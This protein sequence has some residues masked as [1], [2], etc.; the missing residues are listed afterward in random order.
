MTFAMACNCTAQSS[1]DPYPVDP[2]GHCKSCKKIQSGS[3]PDIIFIKPDGSLIRIAQIR[4]LSHVIT[5]KPYGARLRVVVI[6]NAQTMNPEAG[7]ALLKLLEE[8]PDRTI[9]ILTA[10]QTSDLLPTI[11]SRC[12]HIRFNPISQKE[13]MKMLVTKQEVAPDDAEII[14]TMA[15]GS[16]SKAISIAR[17]VNKVNWINRRNWLINIISQNFLDRSESLSLKPI[18][19]LL[20]F[21]AKLSQNKEILSDSLNV[22]KSYLRD[23][24][25]CKYCPEKIIN[26]DL[27]DNIQYTSQKIAVRSLL[28]KIEAVRRTQRDIETNAN[29]R[30]T[31][32]AMI[33]QLRARTKIT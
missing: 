26:K 27:A 13:I 30:M 17:S 11:V 28:S 33:M 24:V 7:N 15:N 20:A 3:H 14:V 29:I 22:I 23:L 10:I 4:A 21:A 32:E 16:F 9:L 5:M 1:V 18:G 6:S 2:C 19:S 12:Q 31:L 8:P 25:I